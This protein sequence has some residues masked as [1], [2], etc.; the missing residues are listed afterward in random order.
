MPIRIAFVGA[1][2]MAREHGRAFRDIPGVILSGIHSR[3]RA[4]A[5]ALAG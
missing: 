3:T 4:K 1:G 5:E 2:G